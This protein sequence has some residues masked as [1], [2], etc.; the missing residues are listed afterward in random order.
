MIATKRTYP[1]FSNSNVYSY[2]TNP[3]ENMFF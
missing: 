3:W 2:K 1:N